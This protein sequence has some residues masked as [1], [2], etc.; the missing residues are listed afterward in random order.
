MGAYVLVDVDEPDV[1]LIG[2]GS[3]VQLCADAA[4]ELTAS[5]VSAR[6]VS[7]PCWELFEA[8]EQTYRDSVLIPGTATVSVEAGTSFGWSR[9]ADAHVAIDGFGTSAPGSVAMTEFGMTTA[10]VVA[11]APTDHHLTSLIR[12]DQTKLNQKEDGNQ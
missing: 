11:T 2:T 9:W 5:G 10:N 7:M 1:I 12:S 3:E 6:V 8:Q 4:A